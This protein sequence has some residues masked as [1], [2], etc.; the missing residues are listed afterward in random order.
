MS[1]R[2][3][4]PWALMRHHA[5]WADVFHIENETADSIT[6]FYPDRETVGPPVNYSVRAVLARFPTMEAARAARE[7]AVL[8]W[9]KH[10]AGVREAEDKLRA[11]EKAREDAWLNCLRGAADG[12]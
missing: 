10:D 3:E 1:D 5:G 9:R 4:R 2:I 12:K 6:G 8:E 11:A 7:G